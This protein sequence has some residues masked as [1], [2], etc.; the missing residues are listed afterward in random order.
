MDNQ[1]EHSKEQLGYLFNVEILVKSEKNAEALQLLLQLLNNNEHVIDYR[2]N[3]GIELGEIIDSLLA[4]KKQT[5][6]S[7]SFSRFSRGEGNKS[8]TTPENRVLEPVKEP[9]KEQGA[10]K[11]GGSI[12][13]EM[14]GSQNFQEW[15]QKFITKNALV[16]LIVDHNDKRLSIPCRILNFQPETFTI[17]IY[18]VDEKQV[19][20]YKLSEIVDFIDT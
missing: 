5:I 4:A 3:S 13:K 10:N 1:S 18:H 6:I 15:I 16:R 2:I 17:T 9:A 19:Y 14:A 8:T 20:T 12:F 7:K 11:Q